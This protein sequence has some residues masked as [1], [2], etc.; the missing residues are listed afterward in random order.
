MSGYQ[1]KKLVIHV[2]PLLLKL[3]LYNSAIPQRSVLH[4][5][6]EATGNPITTQRLDSLTT[7]PVLSTVLGKRVKGAFLP[8]PNAELAAAFSGTDEI[9]SV[10]AESGEPIPLERIKAHYWTEPQDGEDWQMF[11][12]RMK[13]TGIKLHFIF[14]DGRQQR[15]AVLGFW[16]QNLAMVVLNFPSELR[17]GKPFTPVCVPELREKADEFIK[18]LY[19]TKLD[20]SENIKDQIIDEIIRR[21][22]GNPTALVTKKAEA[23][24]SKSLE[25]NH[26]YDY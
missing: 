9:W 22:L 12:G 19:E 4:L 16:G 25:L 2:G 10:R 15:E 3:K 13:E 17:V 7:D 24:I 5:A 1:G 8:I 26:L 18:D 11:G 21:K 23:L 20:T 14:V 6:N